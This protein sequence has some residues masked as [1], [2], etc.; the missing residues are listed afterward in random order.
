MADGSAIFD[1]I[2]GVLA[3]KNLKRL[4]M[5]KIIGIKSQNI[6]NIKKSIPA[7]DTAIKIADYLRV[8][9]KWLITGEDDVDISNDDREFIFLFKQ[10]D[11]DDKD[12]ITEFI[13][14]KLK[15]REKDDALSNSEI[16]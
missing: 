8:S 12:E 11:S 7:A 2:I 9:V 4:D 10:L 15:K 14:L 5:C 3:E 13:R 16:A 1:R 6:T